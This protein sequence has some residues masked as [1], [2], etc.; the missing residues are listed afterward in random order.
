MK[1]A[2]DYQAFLIQEYGG[3]SRYY[4]KLTE[5]LNLFPDVDAKIFAPLHVNAYLS[6]LPSDVVSGYDVRHRRKRKKLFRAINKIVSRH[7][8]SRYCPDVVHETYYSENSVAPSGVPLVVTIHDMVHER[9]PDM[10]S[11]Q[12]RTSARKR[13]AVQ[14]ADHIICISN[15]TRNDLIDIFNVSDE[16]ISVVY[17]GFEEFPN[18]H[19]DSSVVLS[20]GKPYLLYVGQRSGY[21]NFVSFITAYSKS[22]RLKKEV[23]VVCF[24]DSPFRHNELQLFA[25]LGLSPSQ[26]VHAGGD[27]HALVHAYKNAVAFVYPSLYEGFGIPPLEA[28]SLSCPVICSHSSSIP[29]VVGNAAEYFDPT[30]I[31][32]IRESLEHVVFSSTRRS[33][34]V[35]SGLDRYRMFTWDRCAEETLGIYQSLVCN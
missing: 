27:D 28:M 24:G 22:E 26:V 16:K 23:A 35:Q 15:C 5:T 30:S 33:E 1:I 12:D 4:S 17:H 29:E 32:S 9:F 3:I 34:L 21:K 11:Q 18:E 31:E 7:Q 10:F 8:M 20:N 25:E 6:K 2:F 13:E 14:R 19:I